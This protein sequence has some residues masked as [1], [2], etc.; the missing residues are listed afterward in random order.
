[1]KSRLVRSFNMTIGLAVTVAL[2]WLFFKDTDWAAVGA[3]IAS[4]N[5]LLLLVA[6]AGN[7]LSVL[8]RAWRWRLLLQHLNPRVRYLQVLSAYVAGFATSSLLPGRLGEIVRPALMSRD[9]GIPFMSGLATLVTER[10]SDLVA[11]LALVASGFVFTDVI[12]QSAA[13][14]EA[15]V[16]VD[17]VRWVSM[18][19]LAVAAAASLF[20]LLMLLDA[21][22]A[23]ALA[24]FFL[25]PLP[26]K[27]GDSLMRLLDRFIDGL[28]GMR[29][30]GRF[31]LFLLM[32]AAN[33]LLIA[34]NV[35]C[36]LSA[37]GIGIP[38]HFA[39]FLLGVTAL[40]VAI[41]SPAGAGTY[42]A[43]VILVLTLI[44]GVAPDLARSYALVMHL[45][46]FSPFIIGGIPLLLT[47]NIS[48]LKAEREVSTTTVG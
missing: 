11:V 39:L 6:A 13:G 33:W 38:Y 23:A 47:G 19:S 16:F 41:P 20:L 17:T 30:R 32:T 45:I 25:K 4:A 26:Q 1:M 22:R 8:L 3:A 21:R 7:C 28:G 34:G 40:G 24:R 9:A 14:S 46:T 15:A 31:A 12:G 10:I 27:I 29:V 42:H 43:A 5:L 37:F 36:A 44:W 35:W 48:V 2:F 18:I